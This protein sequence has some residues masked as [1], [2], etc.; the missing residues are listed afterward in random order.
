MLAAWAMG[1]G[2]VHAAVY[3]EDLVRELLG[4]PKGWR[5]DYVLSFGYPA[6]MPSEP[7][8]R[9]PLEELVH[10]DRW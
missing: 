8:E 5:C 10:R 6:R 3:D 1:I 4:Y 7:G 9:R 2:S